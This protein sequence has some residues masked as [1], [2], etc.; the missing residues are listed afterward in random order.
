MSRRKTTTSSTNWR[1]RGAITLTREGFSPFHLLPSGQIVDDLGRSGPD[2]VPDW[3]VEGL[4]PNARPATPSEIEAEFAR[5]MALSPAEIE[6]VCSS[7][8]AL[9]VVGVRS[10]A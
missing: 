10:D 2:F 4:T 1:E 3:V 8:E 6:A 7:Q 9:A 5:L